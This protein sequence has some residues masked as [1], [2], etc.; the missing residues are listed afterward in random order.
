MRLVTLERLNSAMDDV[1]GDFR[2]LGMWNDKLYAVDVFLVP[3]GYALGWKWNGPGGHISIPAVSLSRLGS[4]MFGFGQ[5]WGLRDVVRHEYG[6][7]VADLYPRLSRS[8]GFR[9]AFEGSYD[10]VPAMREYDPDH[11]V[12][13][14]AARRPCEDF[15][16]V[17]MYY[18]KMR[19]RMPSRF[20]TPA[21]RRKWRFAEH[22]IGAIRKGRN[23]F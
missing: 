10:W 19:G 22:M 13:G 7:A 4:T 14:Y 17:F 21:I 15:A 5:K 20:D 18:I 2:H 9:K 6:H 16:E 8:S 11:H 3:V 23:T 1:I 12:T